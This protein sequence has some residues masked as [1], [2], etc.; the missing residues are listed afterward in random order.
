M[1]AGFKTLGCKE[2]TLVP[3]D[4]FPGVWAYYDAGAPKTIVM[5]MMYD[6]QPF[7]EK[8]WSSPPLE[9]RVAKMAPYEQVILARGAINSKGP[10][11][12]F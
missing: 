2:A 11:A 5:Y 12:R 9:A 4:G 7:D 1:V 6:T 8:R 10:I 3:T